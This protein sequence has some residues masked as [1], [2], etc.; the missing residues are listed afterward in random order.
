MP[1]K[2]TDLV[3][4][5]VPAPPLP[6]SATDIGEA[7]ATPESPLTNDQLVVEALTIEDY[8]KQQNDALK[9]RSTRSS[10]SA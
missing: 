6:P 2:K 7:M 8:V 1:R 5:A 9:K 3:A 10:C 4:A